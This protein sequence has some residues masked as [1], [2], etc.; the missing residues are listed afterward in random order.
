MM[1]KF[2]RQLWHIG[3][4]FWMIPTVSI[5]PQSSLTFQNEICKAGLEYSILN[6]K[7]DQIVIVREEPSP[8]SIIVGVAQQP[9]ICS[10]AIMAS[11]PKTGLEMFCQEADAA[12][13]AFQATWNF[14]AWQ[15]I[16]CDATIRELHETESEHAFKELW[17]NR[18]GQSGTSL[19]IFGKPIRGGGLR[20]VLDPLPNEDNPIQIEVKIE[21]FL[22]DV[23]KIYVET[24]FNWPNASTPSPE[25]NVIDRLNNMNRYI[26]E[27]VQVFI[28]GGSGAN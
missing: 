15:I 4:N 10:L 14:P 17:E 2:S 23:K 27:R 5:S 24:I 22:S 6:L 26:E 1:K 28:Q 11:T 8:L 25:I 21:S 20:F 16:K 18:L 19:S 7:N 12:V 9:P 13:K 3:I